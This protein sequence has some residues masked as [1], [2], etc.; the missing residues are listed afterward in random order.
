MLFISVNV[1][2]LT[3]SVSIPAVFKNIQNILV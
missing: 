2:I 1:D 3:L